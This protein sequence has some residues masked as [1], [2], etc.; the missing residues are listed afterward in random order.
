MPLKIVNIMATYRDFTF[1]LH[2]TQAKWVCFFIYT[3]LFAQIFFFCKGVYF[4]KKLIVI[5]ITIE[6]KFFVSR[7]SWL[8]LFRDCGLELCSFVLQWFPVTSKVQNDTASRHLWSMRNFVEINT[9]V[10][11]NKQIEINTS[12]VTKRKKIIYMLLSGC[13]CSFCTWLLSLITHWENNI[14]K[15]IKVADDFLRSALSI[16]NMWW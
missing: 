16:L 11:I 8:S 12:N 13:I 14:I 9:Y 7:E 5:S 3:W 15:I 6:R 2:L 10:C 4:V 1:I